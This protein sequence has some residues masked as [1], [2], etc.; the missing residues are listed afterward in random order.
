MNERILKWLYDIQAAII[1]IDSY[2]EDYPLELEVY[3]SNT[4][5]KRAVERDL[6]IMGKQ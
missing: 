5:L 2:F 4:L 1:E 3:K 6:E